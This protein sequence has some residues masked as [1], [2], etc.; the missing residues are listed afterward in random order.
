MHVFEA[1]PAEVMRHLE[2]RD[3]LIVYPDWAAQYSELK[4]ELVKIHAGNKAR[5][6]DGKDPFIKKIDSLVAAKTNG[7]R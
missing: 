5:Y 4:Q 7:K 6:V 3:F 1:D 2:F